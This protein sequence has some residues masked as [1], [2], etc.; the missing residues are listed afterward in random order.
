MGWLR[1]IK[2]FERMR[3]RGRERWDKNGIREREGW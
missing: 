2:E 3:E 1:I